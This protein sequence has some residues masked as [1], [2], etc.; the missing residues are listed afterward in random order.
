MVNEVGKLTRRVGSDRVSETPGDG[1]P[2]RRTITASA[3]APFDVSPT[4]FDRLADRNAGRV[5]VEW[6]WA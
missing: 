1:S 3:H 6:E 5:G 2:N 4:M